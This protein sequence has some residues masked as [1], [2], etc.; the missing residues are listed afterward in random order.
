MSRAWAIGELG[1]ACVAWNAAHD[2]ERQIGR[3]IV[4]RVEKGSIAINRLSLS[5]L[6]EANISLHADQVRAIEMALQNPVSVLTGGPGM[7]KCLGRGTPVLLGNHMPIAV[8]LI[9]VGDSLLHPNGDKTRVRSVTSGFSDL[10]RLTFSM[11]GHPCANDVVVNDDHL[12]HLWVY[13]GMSEKGDFLGEFR[14]VTA[15]DFFETNPYERKQFWAWRPILSG[16]QP[17]YFLADSVA[18]YVA[19]ITELSSKTHL[20]WLRCCRVS[21]LRNP[22]ERRREFCRVFRRLLEGTELWV[23]HPEAMEFVA[24]MFCSVGEFAYVEPQIGLHFPR[25]SPKRTEHQALFSVSIRYEG[26]GEYFGFELDREDGLFLLGDYTVTHNTT[27][28][29]FIVDQARKYGSEVTLCAP[30]GR[31]ARMMSEATGREASTIHSLLYR[32][33]QPHNSFSIE[34]GLVIIDEASMVDI[35]LLRDFLKIIPFNSTIL[36]V[37]D[38][39]QLPSIGAGNVLSDLIESG[40]VPVTR[41]TRIYRQGDGSG[42]S[43]AA[44]RILK[45]EIPDEAKDFALFPA[46]TD[47][48]IS[49]YLLSILKRILDKSSVR[50]CFERIQIL[51]PIRRGLAGITEL[52]RRIQEMI[53][54]RQKTQKV[55]NNSLY[56]FYVGDKVLQTKN[57]RELGLVN[58]DIG[59]IMGSTSPSEIVVDFSGNLVALPPSHF[60]EVELAYAITI[61]KS[62]GSQFR[63]VFLAIPSDRA[64]LTRNLLYTA[65]TRAVKSVLIFGAESEWHAAIAAKSQGKRHTELTHF[66]KSFTEF[67]DGVLGQ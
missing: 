51:S 35:F 41:L 39:D 54:R 53:Q 13:E 10:F 46:E 37:G 63:E 43:A 25:V 31:A 22:L 14:L 42:I 9:Q 21:W 45:G 33:A 24:L 11:D 52:N 27:V 56:D 26:R 1:S 49:L 59:W 57:R 2:A 29:R 66:L 32:A 48:E 23:G 7:G 50:T 19:R 55:A 38:K 15:R 18:S 20:H 30:T 60:V 36:F 67:G 12:L 6:D 61:H 5:V 58:G 65:I 34:Q 17:E 3:D 47:K 8:E 64:M 44:L 4:N 28:T 62:Q 16:S 40:A